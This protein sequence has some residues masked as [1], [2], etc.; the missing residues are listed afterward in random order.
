VEFRGKRG[1]DEKEG[2]NVWG[3]YD[4]LKMLTVCGE[5]NMEFGGVFW[6]YLAYVPLECQKG[7]ISRNL[8][9]CGP[10]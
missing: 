8:A 6:G 4:R 5:F 2:S 7:A 1:E 3:L 10:T 9:V